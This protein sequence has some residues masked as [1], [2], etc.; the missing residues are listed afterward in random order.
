MAQEIKKPEASTRPMQ[1]HADPFAAMRSEMDRVFDSFLGRGFGPLT[2]PFR[3]EPAET[4]VPS[5]DVRETERELVV[6]AVA[7]LEFLAVDR[8]PAAYHL[9]PGIA[10]L[11]QVMFH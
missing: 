2:M 4:V 11:M 6:E 10:S 3:S 1:R 8:H 7:G 5:I 9:D